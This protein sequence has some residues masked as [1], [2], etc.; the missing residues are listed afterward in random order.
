MSTEER[1]LD[2]VLRREELRK[3]GRPVSPEEL[4]LDCPELL[5]ILVK[6]LRS[7]ESMDSLL[8]GDQGSVGSGGL[9]TTPHVGTISIEVPRSAER[10]SFLAM[11]SWESWAGAAWASST[12][13]GNESSTAWWP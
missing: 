12:G 2:L 3:A 6:R 5:P 1:V 8:H 13:P 9:N 10:C 4:C 7:L 11:K